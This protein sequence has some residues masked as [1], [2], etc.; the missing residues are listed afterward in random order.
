MAEKP[1][2]GITPGMNQE[3]TY[4]TIHKG[5]MDA[6]LHYG[7]LPV[8]LPM[9]A[10]QG[11]LSAMLDRM[12]GVVFS[13]GGDIDPLRFG[14]LPE[15]NCGAIS[16]MRDEMELTLCHLLLE[17]PEKAALGICRGFQVMNVA[18]GGDVVQD[19]FTQYPEAMLHRQKQ[20]EQY[21][22]H[23]VAIE[24]GTLLHRCVQETGVTVNSLHHQAVGR[25]GEGFRICAKAPDGIIEA[26]EGEGRPFFLGVQ[27]HPER[28]WKT[29]CISQRIFLAFV[30]ACE[31]AQGV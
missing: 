5:T 16:P 14:Q 28:L 22:S 6:L 4:L 30:R 27:W 20:P 18:L 25:V 10:D 21:P 1:V 11:A 8:L 29:D 12:D 23:P 13:G 17:R 7:A 19:I 31:G 24:E 26:A 2:I 3:E 15:K 9:T